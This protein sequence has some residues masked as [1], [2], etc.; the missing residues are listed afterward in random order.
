MEYKTQRDTCG[1][2]NAQVK[3]RPSEIHVYMAFMRLSVCI[4]SRLKFPAA[5]TIAITNQKGSI[6]LII[7]NVLAVTAWVNIAVKPASTR[8]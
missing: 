1:I 8:D 5:T 2:D 6:I 7:I 4:A 3:C